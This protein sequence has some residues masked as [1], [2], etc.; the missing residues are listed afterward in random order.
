MELWIAWWSAVFALR[1]ACSRT[2]TFMW[3]LVAVAGFCVRSDLLGVT[4]IV[5][6]LG[7]VPTCYG[8]L[9]DFFHSAALDPDLLARCWRALVLRIFP[10]IPR[11]NGRLVL[12]ADGIK[13]PKEGRKMPAVKKLH[14]SSDSN[15]KPNYIMGHSCQAV[16]LL[17]GSGNGLFAVPLASRIHEGV[18]FSNRDRRTLYDKLLALIAII[19]VHTPFYLVAD[20]YY[21]C[22]KMAWGLMINGNHLIT[23]V[24]KNAVAWTVPVADTGGAR[25]RGRPRKYGEKVKLIS[26]FDQPA[27]MIAADSPLYGEKDV[28]IHYLCID[29]IWRP[30]G[31]LVRFVLVIHPQRGRCILLSTDR[32]LDAIDI[33]KLYGWRCKIEVAFK[34]ALRVLGGYA[35]HFWMRDMKPLKRGSGNQYPHRETHEY[36][37]AIRRKIDAYHRFIQVACV[38]QGMLQYLAV[39]FPDL[40]WKQFGSWLRTIRPGVAPSEMV[41]ALA[42]RNSLPEFL[43]RP[44]FAGAEIIAFLRARIDIGQVQGLRLYG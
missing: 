35:Y 39:T 33:I 31:F 17:V 25:R 13:I 22:R 4:S 42:L 5:R 29:L 1:P 8:Q 9:L 30:L 44:I 40:V 43:A 2:R 26:L 24:H 10:D 7:L 15:T 20:A 27:E 6:G 37:Q 18:V 11:F 34:A 16:S 36:R 12:L 19:D 41:A 14:Q 38:A 28:T 3:L 23:R 32:T 21:A